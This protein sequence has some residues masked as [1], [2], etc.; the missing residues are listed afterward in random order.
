MITEDLR[1]IYPQLMDDVN[2]RLIELQVGSLRSALCPCT[3]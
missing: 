1:K 2:I 3:N